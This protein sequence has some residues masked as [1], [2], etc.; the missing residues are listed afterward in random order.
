M[1]LPPGF[2]VQLLPDGARGGTDLSDEIL[3]FWADHGGPPPGAA[4]GRLPLLVALLRDADG[5]LRATSSAVEGDVGPVGNRRFWIW[6]CL[7]PDAEARSCIEPF[8]AA[9]RE[10]LADRPGSTDAKPVGI[11]FP[12]ADPKLLA[13]HDAAF[14]PEPKMFYAGWART[15]Q[16]LRIS[17]FDG[18]TIR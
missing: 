10:L 8:A 4:P 2:E 11:C 17:Y 13:E 7:L 3:A 18:V 12:V 16:Q 14:W 15:G 9:A 5:R 1:S 6:R